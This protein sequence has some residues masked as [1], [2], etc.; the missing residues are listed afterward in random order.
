MSMYLFATHTR[1]YP[2]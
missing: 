2:L 1:R